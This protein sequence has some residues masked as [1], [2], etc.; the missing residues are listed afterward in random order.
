[1]VRGENPHI[2]G[3]GETT[4]DFCY[5][6]NVVQA[7]LLAATAGK[8]ASNAVYNIAVG[9][10][11]SLNE[12]LDAIRAALGACGKRVEPDP[13]YEDFRAGDV[14]HSLAN[15]DK[16]ARELGYAPEFRIREGLQI[17][18]PWY[19]RFIGETSA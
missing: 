9:N 18:M 2:Y 6:D 13:V 12:L 5:I 16:A 1:M 10:R 15:I 3:D 14:R 8:T 17:A 11:T 19:L 7:N 4:R